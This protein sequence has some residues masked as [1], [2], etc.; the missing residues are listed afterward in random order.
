MK[1]CLIVTR[2]F[3]YHR[4]PSNPHK[5]LHFKK[6]EFIYIGDDHHYVES[7]GWLVSLHTDTH[8][9]FFIP[10]AYLEKYY[11]NNLYMYSDIALSINYHQLKV[12][13]SLDRRDAELFQYHSTQLSYW[14]QLMNGSDEKQKVVSL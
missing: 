4:G 11:L 13:Q 5:C 10:S 9:P 14:N 7:I 2:D 6:G 3:T 1:D 12:D 8:P